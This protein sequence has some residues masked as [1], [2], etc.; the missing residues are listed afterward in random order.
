MFTLCWEVDMLLLLLFWASR[1]SWILEYCSRDFLVWSTEVG[2]VC[3][4]SCSELFL[5]FSDGWNEHC[6]CRTHTAVFTYF[7]LPCWWGKRRRKFQ[8]EYWIPGFEKLAGEELWHY[9]SAKWW[10]VVWKSVR[11][12]DMKPW[13]ASFYCHCPC[14]APL[15]LWAPVTEFCCS[16]VFTFCFAVPCS[17]MFFV[18]I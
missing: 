7:H 5:C 17:E 15:L 11:A 3:G 4:V 16:C 6:R 2:M 1:R 13:S 10:R 18:H 8:H 12:K 14:L 9:W